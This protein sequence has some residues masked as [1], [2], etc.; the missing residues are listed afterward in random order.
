MILLTGCANTAATIQPTP[1]AEATVSPP[2][3][4]QTNTSTFPSA[5]EQ[6]PAPSLPP[7]HLIGVRLV[8]GTAKFY[9]SQTGKEFVPR[10]ANYVF[11]PYTGTDSNLLFK[12]GVYDPI[13]TRQD[14]GDLAALDYN[15]VRVFL[16]HCSAGP[17]CIG[18]MDNE[19]LNP[20][21]LDNITDMLAA[22][23]ETGIFILFTSNDLPDQGGYAEQA[24]AQ[25]GSTFAGYRN[26]YYLTPGAVDATKRYWRD[27]LTG[28]KSRQAATEMVLGWQ[29]LN[30]QWMFIDQPPLSLISGHVTTS[31][32]TYNM[33]DPAQKIL[34]VNEG[35]IHYITEVKTEIL[36]HDP[37]ALVTMGFFAPEIVAPGWYVETASLLAGA[38]LDFF[39]F[40]AYPGGEN[41]NDLVNAFGMVDYHTKPI[42]LGEFG[43]F[44]TIYDSIKPAARAIVDWQSESCDLGFDGWLYWTYYPA[45][46]GI[47][48]RT[49]GLVDE[50]GF[51]LDLLSPANHPD[52]C[53]PITI[54][55]D[56]LA[57][58]KPV[59]A[60]AS[61]LEEPPSD[62]VD[63]IAST[64]WGA[65]TEAPQ[66]IEINL[67]RSYQISEIRLLVAQWPSGE[68]IHRV[69]GRAAEGSFSE[70]HTF[71]QATKAGDWLIFT[72]ETLISDIQIIRIDT[73][74]SPSW[75]AWSEIEVFG[76]LTD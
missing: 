47:S 63:E 19:G 17:G 2:E 23:R 67:E 10:G 64:Q 14:F 13:R 42:I 20:V 25:Q 58:Q 30:E 53:L 24:N 68:T 72:P 34:M 48:D 35:L 32:G 15:T 3:I 4:R 75:V 29:L 69:R 22:A 73:L 54:V 38:D 16:D 31:T 39:D 46:P 33:G 44:R 36:A 70:L 28:L 5:T 21:Y 50:S 74:R 56:N 40:H 76:A 45:D 62:A 57:Y 66:W 11:I 52:P 55:S 65:G 43:A 49:W 59:V 41:L 71:Q 60:S 12:V 8:D 1:S 18:D 9:S 27:L 7:E 51:L 26:S 61:L 6:I 37:T